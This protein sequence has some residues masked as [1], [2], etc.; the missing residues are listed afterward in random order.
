MTEEKTKISESSSEEKKSKKLSREEFEKKVVEL[1]KQGITAEKIGETL[2]KQGIHSKE[3]PKKILK[4]LK[5]N[6]LGIDPDLKNV[7]TK[8]EAIKKH[9]EKNRQDKRAMREK[10]RVFSQLRIL[11][12][13]IAKRKN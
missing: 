8:L 11:K 9:S 3:Y 4:I 7:E 10:D 2:R 13:Y 6:K 5:E 12:K 1:G